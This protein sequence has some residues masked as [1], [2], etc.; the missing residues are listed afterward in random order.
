M[1]LKT[2][3][4]PTLITMQENLVQSFPGDLLDALPDA[5]VWMH[6]VFDTADTIQDFEVAYANHAASA[7]R[8]ILGMRVLA[9]G[10]PSPQ[11]SGNHFSALL[12]VLQTGISQEH[13]AYHAGKATQTNT[14]SKVYK[15]GV[16]QTSRDC[17]LKD[18]QDSSEDVNR[19]TLISIVENAPI[20]IL[21]YEAVRNE[22]GSI[23]DFRIKYY[24]SQSGELTGLTGAQREALGFRAVLK[25]F[26]AEESIAQYINLVETGVSF[27]R[28]QYI[29]DLDKWIIGSIVKFDDGFI[30]ML[31]DVTELKRS[32]NLMR[33]ESQLLASILDGSI[34]GLFVLQA[35]RDESG[36][37]TDFLIVQGN[38]RFVEVVGKPREAV[39]GA[40]Y[41]ATLP[42]S[43]DNGLF[44]LKK[45]ILETGEPLTKEFQYRGAGID[46]WFLISMAPWGT[47]GIVET[48][49]DITESKLDKQR[50][51]EAAHRFETVVNTSKAGM[52]TLQPVY[53][54]AG[55]IHDFRFV[56]VNQAVASYIGQTA[57]VLTGAL[58]SI[59]FPAYTTNGL[60]HIYK[61]CLETGKASNFDFHYE[62]G[63]DVFFNIDVV[64]MGSEVLVTFTD[65][66]AL[67]RLQREM[68][69]NMSE[70]KRLN[71]DL[72]EFAYAAS[73]DLKEPVRKIKFFSDRLQQK[74]Q[75]RM[76][77]E[78]KSIMSRIEKSAYRMGLLI[79]EL[80]TYSQTSRGIDH[81]ETID[82]NQK[83][84]V[85]LE[86]LELSIQDKKATV[87]IG[88]MPSVKGNRRQLQQ[89]FQNLIGNAL[90]YCKPGEVPEIAISARRVKGKDTTASLSDEDMHKDFQ[91]IEVADKGIGFDQADAE[92]IFN[93]FTR[94]HGRSEYLGTGVGLSIAKKVVE[95]HHGYIWAASSPG[96]GA[97]FFILLP[98]E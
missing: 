71:A 88:H 10:L 36:A 31:S 81:F 78:E 8:P 27:Q 9:D 96:Q 6:P 53:D 5:I 46:G 28:E 52:F 97:T 34:N 84:S 57:E 35:I 61:E 25:L 50:I 92:R 82:L 47:D 62:D 58:A 91:L 64:R 18:A 42:P 11:A 73:H 60:F 83:L 70:L 44:E 1:V 48:F 93:V 54:E 55:D 43:R 56:I 98:A 38:K 85:V 86:D 68:E 3:I 30:S 4:L 72:E 67:K 16:L 76:S 24:N 17:S 69:R 66:T 40:S 23:H 26:G 19:R 15:G 14:V 63:Y 77:T 41:L 21:L 75:D 33:T 45:R 51:E 49:T 39:I 74:M 79:D 22:A 20:G 37:I 2:D 89:L 13:V 12:K 80:L 29:K 32:Q 87:Q 65:F 90:K 59:Y 7:G 95:N 94:L